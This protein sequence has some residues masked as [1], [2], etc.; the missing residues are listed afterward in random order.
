MRLSVRKYNIQT[1]QSIE[2]DIDVE[3][4]ENGKARDWEIKNVK[5]RVNDI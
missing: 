1:Y 4:V 3:V 2:V 5:I